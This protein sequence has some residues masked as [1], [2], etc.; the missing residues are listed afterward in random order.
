MLFGIYGYFMFSRL[1]WNRKPA[2]IKKT[3][4]NKNQLTMENL[5]LE[6]VLYNQRQTDHSDI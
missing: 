3:K 5:G 2:D 4:T 1:I 6:L